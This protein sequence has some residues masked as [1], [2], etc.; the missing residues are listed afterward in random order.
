MLTLIRGLPGSGK[1]TKAKALMKQHGGYHFEADM[2]FVDK[3]GRYRFNPAKLPQA[4]QWCFESTVNKLKQGE[5][6]YVSN[7]F[8]EHWELN[9]YRQLAAELQVEITEIICDGQYDNIHN[10]PIE[11]IADMRR[12]WQP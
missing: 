7:T 3:R 5:R 1:S 2:Y 4:H 10:V 8:V 12:R 6:V 11:V 9:Q